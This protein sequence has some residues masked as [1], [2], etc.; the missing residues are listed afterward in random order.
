MGPLNKKNGKE[1]MRPNIEEK[2]DRLRNENMKMISD[3]NTYLKRKNR[4]VLKR[5]YVNY[6]YNEYGDSRRINELFRSWSVEYKNAREEA[7]AL[8]EE[9]ERQSN[10][11]NTIPRL[12]EGIRD[13]VAVLK[14]AVFVS[15]Y[16]IDQ[17][18]EAYPA[19]EELGKDSEETTLKYRAVH[20]ELEKKS[21]TITG[22][23]QKF[24]TVKNE[25]EWVE[26]CLSENKEELAPL[27]KTENSLKDELAEIT[28]RFNRQ[29]E[30]REEKRV[31][32]EAIGHLERSLGEKKEKLENH[33]TKT[34]NINEEIKNLKEESENQKSKLKEY[35]AL[36]IPFQELMEKLKSVKREFT[37][38][39]SQQVKLKDEIPNLKKENE[40]LQTKARQF[41]DIKKMM[42]GI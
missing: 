38:L 28:Q 23:R 10:D 25:K 24:E 5:D 41:E 2:K 16:E 20:D 14:K 36:V 4:L 12:V 31:L 3:L 17:I 33:E 13:D 26:K 21:R 7:V 32:D 9:Y 22:L 11:I 42:E 34:A 29:E 27:L 37:L 40:I 39:D 15:K 6:K 1:G 30:L 8:R 18:L 19:L 35:E